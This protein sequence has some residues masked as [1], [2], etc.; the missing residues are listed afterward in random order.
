MNFS[1]NQYRLDNN[2]FPEHVYYHKGREHAAYHWGRSPG[3]KWSEGNIAAYHRGYN[4]YLAELKTKT[5]AR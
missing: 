5:A 3:G 1:I 4:D 2:L